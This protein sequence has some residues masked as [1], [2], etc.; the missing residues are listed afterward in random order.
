[1]IDLE[2]RKILHQFILLDLALRSVQH[3]YPLIEALPLKM[4][5][6]YFIKLDALLKSLQQ[7][8]FTLKKILQKQHIRIIRWQRIDDYFSDLYVTTVGNDEVIRYANHHLKQSVEE[9]LVSRIQ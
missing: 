5:K 8:H 4:H 9:L 6:I 1:M 3:D 7:E 2:N